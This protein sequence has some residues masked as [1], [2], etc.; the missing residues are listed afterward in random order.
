[1]FVFYRC[2]ILLLNF[3]HFILLCFRR[4]E[5]GG[6]KLAEKALKKSTGN[7]NKPTPTKADKTNK[8]TSVPSKPAIKLSSEIS[9]AVRKRSSDSPVTPA[10]KAP[11]PEDVGGSTR[12]VAA[13]AT[14]TKS[15]F[16][17]FFFWKLDFFLTFSLYCFIAVGP[18][19]RDAEPPSVTKASATVN[20]NHTP[21]LRWFWMFSIHLL[22]I[23]LNW[24][25]P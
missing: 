14:L 1:M 22:V 25:E 9:Q 5:E 21:V 12:A 7:A 15:S 19:K 2:R 4:E 8:P 17:H 3:C 6:K 24:L 23:E 16:E 11:R 13:P 18:W 10:K 20:G